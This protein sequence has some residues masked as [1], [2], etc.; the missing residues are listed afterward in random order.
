[1]LLRSQSP[2][3]WSATAAARVADGF[4]LQGRGHGPSRGGNKA[5]APVRG[6]AAPRVPHASS[7]AQQLR[8]PRAAAG[9]FGTSRPRLAG[10][11]WAPT[12]AREPAG[13]SRRRRVQWPRGLCGGDFRRRWPRVAAGFSRVPKPDQNSYLDLINTL[14]TPKFRIL[15]NLSRDST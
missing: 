5:R 15:S 6:A 10:A 7:A 9:P 2:A 13:G 12:N 1:M 3:F 11:V 14:K 8:R 4:G